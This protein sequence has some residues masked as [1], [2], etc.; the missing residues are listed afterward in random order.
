MCNRPLS[1]VNTIG[2]CSSTTECNRERSRRRLG[3]YAREKCELCGEN[4]HPSNVYGVCNRPGECRRE[5]RRRYLA[6][7]RDEVNAS[8]AR[9]KAAKPEKYRAINRRLSLYPSARERKKAWTEANRDRVNESHRRSYHA[10]LEHRRA[11]GRKHS[12]ASRAR[13]RDVYLE[14][15]RKWYAENAERERE[16]TRKWIRAAY[17]SNPEPFLAA[18]RRRRAR[19]RNVPQVDYTRQQVLSL[20]GT[21]CYLCHK[22][23]PDKWHIEHVIPLDPGWDRIENLRPACGPCNSRKNRKMPPVILQARIWYELGV[24]RAGLICELAG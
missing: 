22:P 10:N 13:N 19:K 3:Y 11:L 15:R 6:A 8:I 5:Y 7:N 9:S 2:V 18:G 14:R 23:L 24:H 17:A 12:A 21:D 4:L 1:R 16:R 20:Y